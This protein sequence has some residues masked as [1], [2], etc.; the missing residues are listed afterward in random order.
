MNR[1][2]L[3]P[4]SG[5]DAGDVFM[6][7]LLAFRRDQA[8]T[9]LHREDNL[10]VNWG[11]GVG[12]RTSRVLSAESVCKRKIKAGSGMNCNRTNVAECASGAKSANP[13][14]LIMQQRGAKLRQERHV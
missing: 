4:L 10:D 8:L 13:D 6:K 3:L 7:L 2:Q 14:R 1:K 12:H 9:A 5:H 11:I